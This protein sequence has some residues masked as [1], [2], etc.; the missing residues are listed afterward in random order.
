M[1]PA[2]GTVAGFGSD[3]VWS[4]AGDQAQRSTRCNNPRHCRECSKNRM[5]N[6]MLA[7]LHACM[8]IGIM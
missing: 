2:I 4:V 5:C 7:C 6:C 1:C 3:Q 8:Q